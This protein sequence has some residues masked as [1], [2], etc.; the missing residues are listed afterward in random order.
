MDL[1]SKK[2]KTSRAGKKITSEAGPSMPPP[3][4]ITREVSAAAAALPVMPSLPT[5]C[6]EVKENEEGGFD[7]FVVPDLNVAFVESNKEG[8]SKMMD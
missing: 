4:P 7:K 1:A 6:P 8:P 3:P 2:P 5:T